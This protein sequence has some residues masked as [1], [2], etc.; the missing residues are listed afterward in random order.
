[1]KHI[2]NAGHI[3]SLFRAEESFAVGKLRLAWCQ[4][5]RCC[6][7]ASARAPAGESQKRL[8][9]YL[10]GHIKNAPK[11]AAGDQ[12]SHSR[13]HFQVICMSRYKCLPQRVLP[14]PLLA[15]G[16]GCCQRARPGTKQCGPWGEAVTAPVHA[17]GTP[18][19]VLHGTGPSGSISTPCPTQ[20]RS[21]CPSW[22]TLC[23][24]CASYRP[25]KQ[26]A[27]QTWSSFLPSPSCA[28]L[29]PATQQ[30]SGSAP[31]HLLPIS[32]PPLK[33]PR[34]AAPGTLSTSPFQLHPSAVGPAKRRA[35][36]GKRASALG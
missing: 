18:V 2:N 26:K 21:P 13:G 17:H 5:P 24:F 1:M 25:A 11:N 4:P 28:C 29:S 34:T 33:S 31:R 10:H 7:L 22:I 36:A 23:C 16:R 32:N 8:P 3:G 27:C 15:H 12:L 35:A 9:G 30:L 14:R 19:R 6:L 20:G